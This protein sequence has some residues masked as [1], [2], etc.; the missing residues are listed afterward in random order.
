MSKFQD[1]YLKSIADADAKKEIAA[2]LD[3]KPMEEATDE[4]LEKV[5]AVAKRL[6]FDITVAEARD[7]L[8]P[9]NQKL[10]EDDLDSVAGGGSDKNSKGGGGSS[11]SIHVTGGS[12]SQA[13]GTT[14]TD[15]KVG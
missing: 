6:G 13:V 8:V 3:G 5:G 7:F 9:S 14:Y 12:C 1:F 4:Q 11:P 10:S 2:I 15:V